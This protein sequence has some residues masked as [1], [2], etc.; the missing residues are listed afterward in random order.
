M[1]PPMTRDQAKIFVLP[2][3]TP[4][5]IDDFV[6]YLY[7]YGI[8]WQQYANAGNNFRRNRFIEFAKYYANKR[9]K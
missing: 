1:Q 8:D 5:Q 7:K 9:K 2:K 3:M 6:S 4:D